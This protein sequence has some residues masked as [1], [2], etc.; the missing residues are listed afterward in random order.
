MK[1]YI[2]GLF[3]ALISVAMFTACSADE[4]TDEGN[5]GSARVTLYNYTAEQPYDAD[6]DAYIRVVANSATTEAY[7][8]AEKVSEKEANI[9]K[10]G[11]SGYAD[12]V[13]SNG[14]KLENIKG[15]SVQEEVFQNL[16][17][18]ENAITVVAVGKGGKFASSIIFS[19]VTSIV[20]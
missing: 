4:G 2:Y 3:F 13:V 18:G 17:A 6:C 11:E 1:K 10:M 5:D 20:R 15:A 14:K 19:S 9:A 12:Y 7:A 8:L 16:P